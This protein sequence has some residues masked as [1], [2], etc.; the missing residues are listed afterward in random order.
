MVS[1][2]TLQ[3]KFWQQSL[4]NSFRPAALESWVDSRMN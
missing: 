2:T 4:N 3:S 1:L